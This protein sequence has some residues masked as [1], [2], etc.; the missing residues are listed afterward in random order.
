MAGKYQQATSGCVSAH[1]IE[2]KRLR[3]LR[4]LIVDDHDLV[5][6]GLKQILLEEF[7]DS[8]I[9]EAGDV[10][11]VLKKFIARKWDIVLSDLSMPGGGGIE[12]LQKFRKQAPGIPV[13]IISIYPEELYALIVLKAGAAGFLNKISA[14]AE[15]IKA[16]K[17]ILNGK[18]YI[19]DGVANQISDLGEKFLESLPHE[20]L[21]EREY[22]V[23]KLL[24][25]GK[26]LSEI[27]A[28]LSVSYSSVS[29][30]RRRI[31]TKMKMK[32]NAAIIKYAIIHK[33]ISEQ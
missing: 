31:L 11:T 30:Y 21:S 29:T 33:L 24:A 7:P 28:A 22:A 12:L 15:L 10:D 1:F 8:K 9:E 19:T 6:R 14:S 4:I 23:F 32:N 3:M 25:K 5:R 26:T 2:P 20:V 17:C 27:A 18:K 13:L 16:V